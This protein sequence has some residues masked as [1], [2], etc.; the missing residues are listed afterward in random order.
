MK[1]VSRRVAQAKA[2][3]KFFKYTYKSEE[4][5]V[6][7]VS[8]IRQRG[9][10]RDALKE[11]KKIKRLEQAHHV[12]P[13]EALMQS[14]LVQKAVL[15]GF[16]INGIENGIAFTLRRHKSIHAE[17]GSYNRLVMQELFI[18]EEKFPDCSDKTAKRE[19]RKLVQLLIKEL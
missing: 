9:R 10:L 7:L 19:V 13:I 11:A 1:P 12:I 18:L 4:I 16:E 5:A 8:K 3:L 14:R 15:G 6:R 2:F 17:W